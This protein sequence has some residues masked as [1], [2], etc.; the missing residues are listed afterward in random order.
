[1]G[2]FGPPITLTPRE[3]TLE[4]VVGCFIVL[5]WNGYLIYKWMSNDKKEKAHK[6]DTEILGDVNDRP[7][8]HNTTR[9]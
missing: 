7:S 8:K 1:M 4:D 9:Q 2:G 5:A 6:R 3:M